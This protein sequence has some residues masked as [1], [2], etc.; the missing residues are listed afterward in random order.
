MSDEEHQGYNLF[1]GL[2]MGIIIGAGVVY[3]LTSTEEGKRV[4]KQLKEKGEDVLDDLTDIIEEVEEKGEEFK[5]K[6]LEVQGQL[7]EKTGDVKK[8]ITQEVK[9]GLSQIEE[10]RERGRRA[11]KA[12]TRNG[13]PLA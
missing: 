6:A 2:I 4:K 8:E 9:E 5:K 11:V 12:F 10:L 1:T 7:E 3:F 13:K